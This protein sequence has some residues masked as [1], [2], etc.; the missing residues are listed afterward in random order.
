MLMLKILA[1]LLGV[2]AI[3]YLLL[4]VL[5][6]LEIVAALLPFRL[7]SGLSGKSEDGSPSPTVTV[8]I[9]AHNEART[10]RTTLQNLL[11]EVD[12]PQ[13][14]CVVA[15]NCTDQTADIAKEAGVRVLERMDEQ[16]RG[17]GYALDFGLTQLTTAPPDVVVII[18]ADCQVSPGTLPKIARQAWLENRP[19]QA[20][21][22]MRPPAEASPRD[23]ISAFALTVKNRVRAGGLSALGC[24]I[25]LGGTGMAFPWKTLQTVSLANGHIVED[26]KL[27]IDLA[28]A[29]YFPTLSIETAVTSQLPSGD[30]AATSQRTRWEH[31]H[32]QVLTSY[33]P[34]LLKAALQQGKISL[35]VMGLDLSIPPLALWVVLGVG[36]TTLTGAFWSLTGITWPLIVQGVADG[37][38]VLGILTAW[39]RWGQQDLSLLQ[40]LAVPVYVLWKIPI[41]FKF[42]LKPQSA[43]VR[44]ERDG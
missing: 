36:L 2:A 25:L 39:A 28:I 43:W 5:L 31:G 7:A 40:F 35:L 1:C 41:Y 34:Q 38:L 32:L 4:N 29:G 27:G 9:P 18:D 13:Q 23:R 44:T 12:H 26:M 24:P 15:D 22:R 19:V 21:Y 16:R 30:A 33:V 10:L 20:V 6:S 14:I 11:S 42:V 17:K 3:A 8:L 37:L